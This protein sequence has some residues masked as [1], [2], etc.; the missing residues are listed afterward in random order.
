MIWQFREKGKRP[1]KV[2]I[3]RQWVVFFPKFGST[4]FRSERACQN[5]RV[6]K[7]RWVSPRLSVQ[8]FVLLSW[9]TNRSLRNLAKGGNFRNYRSDIRKRSQT[10]LFFVERQIAVFI[11]KFLGKRRLRHILSF[12]KLVVLATL[13]NISKTLEIEQKQEHREN[14]NTISFR[15]VMKIPYIA[16]FRTTKFRSTKFRTTKFRT[17]KFRKNT[18]HRSR[19]WPFSNW[20]FRKCV[21]RKLHSW[22]ATP[23]RP[24]LSRKEWGCIQ[25]TS[26]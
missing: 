7:F 23:L 5:E 3:W 9:R 16:K 10:S 26:Y 13:K 12:W 11:L 25:T 17:T 18:T 2:L 4:K 15:S 22:S 19:N 6:P 1:Q 20:L 8:N 21:V 14:E 24:V